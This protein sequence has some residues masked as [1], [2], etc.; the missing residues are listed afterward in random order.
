MPWADHARPKLAD[1]LN[2]G[3]KEWT[4]HVVAPGI[5]RVDLIRILDDRHVAAA[6]LDKQP[7][8][9]SRKLI[10]GP[11]FYKGRVEVGLEERGRTLSELWRALWLRFGVRRRARRRGKGRLHSPRKRG[12]TARDV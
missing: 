2:I 4:T 8:S 3:V 12:N 6:H 11:H 5:D 9:R 7:A 1:V 10:L